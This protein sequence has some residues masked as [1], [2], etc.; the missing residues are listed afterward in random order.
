MACTQHDM[1]FISLAYMHACACKINDVET[2][3]QST[4][5]C[6]RYV[7]DNLHDHTCMSVTYTLNLVHMH[8]DVYMNSKPMMML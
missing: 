2:L 3:M 8:I 5:V 1:F 6:S 7:H 4:R